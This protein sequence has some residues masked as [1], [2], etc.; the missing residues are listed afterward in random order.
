[1]HSAKEVVNQMMAN[2]AFSQ[3]LGIE[4][5]EN[6]PGYSKLQ[7]VVRQEMT[8][9]FNIAH[10]GIAYSLADSALAFAGNGRG[11]HAVSIETSIAHTKPAHTD[12]ILI[13]EALEKSH[14][15]RFGIYE[16]TIK[17]QRQELIAL[18]KGTLYRTGKPWEI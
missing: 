12:D 18:F 6:T 10:G 2:D 13:A 15:K 17:N 7:M 1:M 3:W 14:T 9:G 11:T 16:V 5:L 4:V 8:N